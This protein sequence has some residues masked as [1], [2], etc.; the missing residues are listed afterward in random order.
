MPDTE[1]NDSDDQ[2]GEEEKEWCACDVQNPFV[3]GKTEESE[4]Q[5]STTWRIRAYTITI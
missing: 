2:L 4:E 5:V 3:T 1:K